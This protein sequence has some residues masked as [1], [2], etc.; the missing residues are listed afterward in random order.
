[1][2]LILSPDS[3]CDRLGADLSTDVGTVL[4]NLVDNALDAVANS[5]EAT[6]TVEIVSDP[7]QVRIVVA[8]SGP[9]IPQN[10]DDLV[11]ARGFSTKSSTVAGGRGVGLSLVRMI[12]LRRGGWVGVRS[13][14][15]AATAVGAVFT[16][17]LGRVAGDAA[18]ADPAADASERERERA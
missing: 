14:Q 6:V 16:A 7:A 11:F 1:M 13:G 15:D 9:G 4:G 3:H 8:D 2:E 17:V 5:A 12:C 18:D 10:A